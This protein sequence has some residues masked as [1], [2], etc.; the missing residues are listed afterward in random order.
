[1]LSALIVVISTTAVAAPRGLLEGFLDDDGRPVG[2]QA[3]QRRYRLVVFGYT[4]CPDVCPL[5]L[6][7]VHHALAA[8][9]GDATAVDPVFVTVDPDRDSVQKIHDYVSAFD[10]RIRGYRGT[11]QALDRLT[12]RLHVRYWREVLSVD[13]KDYSMSHTAT[14]FLLT[15]NDRVLAKIEHTDNPTALSQAIVNAV[16]TADHRPNADDP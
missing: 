9:A 8:L 7:A 5:T 11:E 10:A 15:R 4:S 14:L 16:R 12:T 1:V 3:L 13:A 6:V 2:K